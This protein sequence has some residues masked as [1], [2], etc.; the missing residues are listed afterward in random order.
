MGPTDD[1]GPHDL[2]AFPV[3]ITRKILLLLSPRDIIPLQRVVPL[4]LTTCTFIP[5]L[6]YLHR[7]LSSSVPSLMITH[8]GPLCM[9][10]LACLDVLGHSL[11]NRP[12]SFNVPLFSRRDW[13]N[14]G[15]HNP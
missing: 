9:P 10:T 13:L 11:G 2:Q 14:D 6:S 8:F 4:S 1:V 15:H 3:E 7:F 12:S 5:Y